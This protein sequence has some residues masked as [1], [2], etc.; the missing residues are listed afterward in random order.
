MVSYTHPSKHTTT[1][2]NATYQETKL[3]HQHAKIKKK[4]TTSL[5]FHRGRKKIYLIL[6]A[7]KY[8]W[9]NSFS[10]TRVLKIHWPGPV[11]WHSHRTRLRCECSRRMHACLVITSGW[12]H[13]VWEVLPLGPCAVICKGE[14]ITQW[15]KG[16]EKCLSSTL[17]EKETSSIGTGLEM[18]RKRLRIKKSVQRG[19]AG[20]EGY[21]LP[22]GRKFLADMNKQNG[23]QFS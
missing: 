18:E 13:A 21:F 19:I 14:E 5:Y 6:K 17:Q 8:Q 1:F 11:T 10:C 15:L 4:S 2:V 12:A 16:S 20:Q 23:L 9:S 22:P 7:K 3:Y